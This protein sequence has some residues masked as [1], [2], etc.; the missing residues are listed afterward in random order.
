MI[1]VATS[2]YV[3]SRP[4]SFDS[5]AWQNNKHLR[6]R[7]VCD[8]LDRNELVGMSRQDVDDTLGRPEGRDSV[9]NGNYS[10]WGGTDGIVDDMWLEID[11]KDDVVTAT[12]YVPDWHACLN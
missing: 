7:M 10:Y 9:H 3:G 1:V 6:P 2:F 12:R 11:F 8:L 4:L 5:T